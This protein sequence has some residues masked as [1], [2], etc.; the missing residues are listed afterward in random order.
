MSLTEYLPAVH[1]LVTECY[2]GADDT[3]RKLGGL[4]VRGQAIAL[5]L[6][7][8][9]RQKSTAYTIARQTVLDLA[10]DLDRLNALLFD[11]L[12]YPSGMFTALRDAELALYNL[13]LYRRGFTTVRGLT[14]GTSS[15][16]Y[17][18]GDLRPLV[19]YIVR[20]G[21]TI[22]RLASRLLGDVTRS[23]EVIDLN[24]LRYPFFDTVGEGPC[25]VGAG[26]ARPGDL[27]YLPPD[28]LIPAAEVSRTQMDVDLYGRD[29]DLTTGYVKLDLD[30]LG[31][32]E[33]VPNITQALL[34]RIRTT[35]GEL[36]LHP[37]Y[38]IETGLIIGTQGTPYQ[39]A[40]NALEIARTVGQDPRVTLV[41]DVV[42]AFKNTTDTVSM[43]V[44]LIGPGQR[45]IPLNMVLPDIVP[46][47][48]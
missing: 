13:L 42:S 34:Q 7:A 45:T 21:D 31:T 43:K 10:G 4:I 25:T 35:A 9:E 2:P 3:E 41:R 33:G 12:A 47:A 38:G 48:P 39:V 29:M 1:Q 20:Q 8:V 11:D 37:E 24:E 15:R 17:P 27:I 44:H 46:T 16:E 5:A 36:V 32:L 28:A 23:W 40:F 22:E 26:I 14:A 19:P 18:A 30:E 6:E